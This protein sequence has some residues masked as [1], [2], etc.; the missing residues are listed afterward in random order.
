[1]GW[2]RSHA[3]LAFLVLS[4]AWV[5]FLYWRGLFNPF[6]S[7]DDMTMIV[8][9]PG[10]ASWHGIGYY[11]HTNVS[12]TGDLRGSGESYYR[13]L[14]WVSLGLDSMLWGS[15]PAG[16]HLTN[17]LLHWMNGF[18]LFS[19]LRR[20]R[21]SLQVAGCTALIWLALPINSEAV[22][23]IAARAYCLAAFFMLVSALLAERFIATRRTLFLILYLLASLCALLSHEAGILV[24]PLTMLLAYALKK[25]TSGAA[26]MLYGASIAAGLLYIG[27][28]H[29]IVHPAYH[30]PGSLIPF[31]VFFFKY[32][33]W[34][35]LPVHMSIER[36]SNTPENILSGQAILAWAGILSILGAAILL[37]RKQPM[38]AAGL[39]WTSIAL[40]PFCGLVPI[41]QGMA[42]R[43]LY[44]ASAGLAFLIVALAFGIPK[45]ARPIA[46]SVV[47]L[48][49]LWGAWRLH[50][51]LLDWADPISL[52][53]SSLEASPRSTKLFYNVGAVSEKRGDLDRADLAY[54]SVLR[55]QPQYEPAI[56]GLGNVLLRRNDPKGAIQLYR[57]ALA[58]KSDDA[59][60]VTNY[61]ASL[62]ELGDLQG[63]ETQYRRAIAFD[64]TKDE[65]YC[66][67]GVLLFQEGNSLGAAVQFIKAQ[68]ADPTDSTPY[69]DLAAVY[70]K[71]GKL[72]VAASLYKKA[73]KLRPDDPDAMAALHR[74]EL[75]Q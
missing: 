25:L 18:L 60:A 30:Q 54:R 47:A 28:R 40:A 27:V 32:I 41:Y 52:Y 72:D 73:L 29:F 55:L 12:F 62:S 13:P 45:R 8:N 7:Y 23:W 15:H 61:A 67:L 11:L 33:G 75:Q 71:L 19:L 17:L 49:V 57:R 43:F 34:L 5:L 38:V 24:L 22:A 66:G 46:L 64:P 44:F 10:L 37:R 48:W 65:A 42:E 6:S 74:L 39:A 59:G 56:A 63:A 53:Q 4:A 51:R 70:Q 3:G 9:N 31:G 21:V 35:A 58:I 14:F 68:R 26:A 69:Y 2:I 1:M 16:F 36:S 50:G 20:L